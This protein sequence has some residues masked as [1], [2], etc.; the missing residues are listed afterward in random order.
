MQNIWRLTW[1]LE[2]TKPNQLG[3]AQKSSVQKGAESTTVTTQRT[4]MGAQCAPP[5]MSLCDVT[6]QPV[7]FT[8]STGINSKAENKTWGLSNIP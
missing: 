1:C 3:F 6:I 8:A 4:A 5:D 7:T 2:N